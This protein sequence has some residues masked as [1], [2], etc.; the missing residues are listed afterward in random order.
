MLTTP[1]FRTIYLSLSPHMKCMLLLNN[2]VLVRF[3]VIVFCFICTFLLNTTKK[4]CSQLKHQLTTI[5]FLRTA[6]EDHLRAENNTKLHRSTKNV[7]AKVTTQ[8]S[9]S[10]TTNNIHTAP[11]TGSNSTSSTRSTGPKWTWFK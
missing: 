2:L 10:Q 4:H 5:A 9:N 6:L 11:A 3:H 7:R 8:S 1:Q